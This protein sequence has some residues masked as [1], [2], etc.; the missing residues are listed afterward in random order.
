MKI[1][2]IKD[3]ITQ[4]EMT[5]CI[6]GR[7]G[8]RYESLKKQLEEALKYTIVLTEP[9]LNVLGDRWK[10]LLDNS[11]ANTLATAKRIANPAT[12]SSRIINS[13]SPDTGYNILGICNTVNAIYGADTIDVGYARLV[14]TSLINAGFITRPKRG[15][16]MKC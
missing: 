14:M 6:S 13:M 16:Y 12:A 9:E 11:I 4:I 10:N 15:E 1:Q 8:D 2:D 7:E 5:G 3:Q